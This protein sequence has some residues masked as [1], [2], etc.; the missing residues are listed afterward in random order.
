MTLLAGSWQ[1]LQQK[2]AL[3]STLHLGT[4]G[5]PLM[6][7]SEPVFPVFLPTLPK[8]PVLWPPSHTDVPVQQRSSPAQLR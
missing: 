1:W 6:G 7:A 4:P 5:L 3:H 2:V 8:L